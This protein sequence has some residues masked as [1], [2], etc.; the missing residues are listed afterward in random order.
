MTD[1]VRTK[2][3]TRPTFVLSSEYCMVWVLYHSIGYL[4]NEDALICGV[5]GV[6]CMAFSSAPDAD[7][8]LFSRLLVK[9]NLLQYHRDVLEGMWGCSD[10]IQRLTSFWDWDHYQSEV[11]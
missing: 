11:F 6:A 4:G 1:V 2:Y 7:T 8:Q 3:V 5:K 10:L 9:H